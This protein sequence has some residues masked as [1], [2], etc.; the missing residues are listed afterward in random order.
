MHSNI[1]IHICTTRNFFGSHNLPPSEAADKETQKHANVALHLAEQYR[2]ALD[3]LL[4]EARGARWRKWRI[5]GAR[6]GLE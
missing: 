5:S 4:P 2:L 6:N 3:A 1:C